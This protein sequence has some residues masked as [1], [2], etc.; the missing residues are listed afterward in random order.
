LSG[1]KN[2]I[3]VEPV[4]YMSPRKFTTDGLQRV[5]TEEIG[6][7]EKEEEKEEREEEDRRWG[8]GEGRGDK[9]K[10]LHDQITYRQYREWIGLRRIETRW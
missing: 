9:K 8:E 7:T 3:P 4:G 5:R 1:G 2:K 10:H 6:R